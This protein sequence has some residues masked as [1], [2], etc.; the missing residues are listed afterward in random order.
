M[1]ETMVMGRKPYTSEKVRIRSDFFF[2]KELHDEIVYLAQKRGLT[3]TQ[4]ANEVFRDYM[5][6]H[7]EELEGMKEWKEKKGDI[8]DSD[9]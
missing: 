8:G 2:D 4:L 7:K 9:E 5:E 1:G 3:K 6:R